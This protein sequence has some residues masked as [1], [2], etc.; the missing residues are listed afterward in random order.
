MSKR[1]L[2]ALAAV[3]GMAALTSIG[4]AVGYTDKHPHPVVGAIVGFSL[5]LLVLAFITAIAASE[6]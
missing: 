2:L 6:G 1:R 4:W 5:G 3:A